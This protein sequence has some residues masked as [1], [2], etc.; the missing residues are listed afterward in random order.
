MR[1]ALR[2]A[3]V[4]RRAPVAGSWPFPHPPRSCPEIPGR[5][6]LAPWTAGPADRPTRC[7]VRR[8]P[9]TVPRDHVDANLPGLRSSSK[10]NRSPWSD[11]LL[12]W[13][14]VRASR[15]I[16]PEG[17]PFAP[18]PTY[19]RRVHSGTGSYPALRLREGH[20]RSHVPP[21]WF[22][23]TSAASSA[24]AGRGL[25]ASRS[26]SWGSRR[27]D[28]CAGRPKV[29]G[30][31]G[32]LAA[33]DSYPSKE[34]PSDSRTASPRPLPPCR[35]SLRAADARAA[36]LLGWRLRRRW[37]QD[38]DFEAL[39]RHRV[40]SGAAPLPTRTEPVLPGLCSPS[41]SFATAGDSLSHRHRVAGGPPRRDRWPKA[42]LVTRRRPR[43]KPGASG[44]HRAANRAAGMP[45]PW[46][47]GTWGP[48]RHARRRGG[49][50]QR[51]P[52]AETAGARLE[53]G[54]RHAEAR[55]GETGPVGIPSTVH[56]R[57]SAPRWRSGA[58]ATGRADG[59]ERG[60]TRDRRPPMPSKSIRS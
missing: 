47:A 8:S 27:F 35:W 41:R 54:P 48:C 24:F 14:P 20:S 43:P 37:A 46:R 12:S 18:P 34:S 17:A 16:G 19:L 2:R 58:E 32:F 28:S 56:R 23:T 22:R 40:R 31:A 30:R 36:P 11:D 13:V 42:P 50:A 21:A 52:T 25:V 44:P 57:A 38:L 49:G 5:P 1:L 10:L 33:Q 7:F 9:D 26:R 6:R 29:G 51:E 15:P 53:P 55:A 59:R 60:R 45:C 4:A 39:L 3:A